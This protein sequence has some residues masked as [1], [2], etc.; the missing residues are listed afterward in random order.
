M[1]QIA[2]WRRCPES[3]A[4]ARN[5]QRTRP[6]LSAQGQGTPL[7]VKFGIEDGAV[8]LAASLI[9]RSSSTQNTVEARYRDQ[10]SRGSLLCVSIVGSESIVG[11]M[12]S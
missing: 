6:C 5:G 2:R 4:S 12:T 8:E 7:R 11:R 1:P 3:Q 10:N 9:V